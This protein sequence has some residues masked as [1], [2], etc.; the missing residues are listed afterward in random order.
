M[1]L[2]A[3]ALPPDGAVSPPSAACL[4]RPDCISRYVRALCEQKEVGGRLFAGRVGLLAPHGTGSNHVVA[5][6]IYHT[7]AA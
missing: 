7:R 5:Y 4:C 3:I 2:K 6:Q 1:M